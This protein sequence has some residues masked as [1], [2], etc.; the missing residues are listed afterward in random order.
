[1]Y[2]GHKYAKEHEPKCDDLMQK[3]AQKLI[4]DALD[5]QNNEDNVTLIANEVD[6]GN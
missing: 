3:S 4:K 5:E 1:M 6:R 2:K